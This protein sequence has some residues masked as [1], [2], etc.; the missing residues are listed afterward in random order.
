MTKEKFKQLWDNIVTPAIQEFLQKNTNYE[1]ECGT[2]KFE[3][4][5]FRTKTKCQQ[6]RPA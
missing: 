1:L 6:A 5:K 4:L 2:A 3:A